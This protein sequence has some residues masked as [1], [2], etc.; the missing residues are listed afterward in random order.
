MG[1][2]I[3]LGTWTPGDGSPQALL[4]EVGDRYTPNREA[5]R[6]A[7]EYYDQFSTDSDG[8][9]MFSEILSKTTEWKLEADPRSGIQIE[10]LSE[11][12]LVPKHEWFRYVFASVL[13]LEPIENRPKPVE[14]P[15]EAE[16]QEEPVV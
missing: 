4:Q 10:E 11:E 15:P 13:L 7:E 12:T 3:R 14:T 1:E 6:T 2:Q 8:H 16:E 5:M 9:I